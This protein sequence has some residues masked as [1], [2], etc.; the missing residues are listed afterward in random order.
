MGLFDNI[1]AS[2]IAVQRNI[3]SGFGFGFN[4]PPPVPK[5]KDKTLDESEKAQVTSIFTNFLN[6]KVTY[7]NDQI[8]QVN[9][10]FNKIGKTL[11]S[12]TQNLNTNIKQ[13][14]K[15]IDYQIEENIS[16]INRSSIVKWNY[17]QDT[18]SQLK[19]QNYILFIIFYILVLVLGTVMYFYSN[20][21]MVVQVA[22][23]HILLIWPFLI[24]YLELFLYI[25][26]S[27]LYSYTYG[28]PYKK[29]YVGDY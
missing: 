11:L 24:Y 12:N 17:E 8:T 20:S 16:K 19:Y 9:D 1:F 6:Q 26:Y 2:I 4:P 15:L 28:V 7:A 10:V 13:E 23:F 14:N 27:Y 22:V 5:S 18:L 29:I 3:F 21:N 25:I